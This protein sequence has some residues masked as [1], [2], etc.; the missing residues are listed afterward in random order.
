MATTSPARIDDELYASAKLAGEVQS[1]SASQQ[2]VHW[3]RI[4]RELEAS[5]S[6]STHDIVEVLAGAR[7][8]DALTA[9]E[10]AVIRAEWAVRADARRGAL[11]LAARFTAEGRAWVELDDECNVVTRG[12]TSGDTD[13]SSEAG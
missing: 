10:Q 12:E 11:D 6:I 9:E 7:S 5:S 2:V 3:A 4:G 8:Y 13:E 1:R